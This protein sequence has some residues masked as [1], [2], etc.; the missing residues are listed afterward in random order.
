GDAEIRVGD[1][2]P[3]AK[4]RRYG[5]SRGD[6]VSLP[7]GESVEEGVE[8]AHLDRADDFKSFAGR[9]RELDGKSGRRAV[10]P[11]EVQRRKI[12]IDEKTDRPQAGQVRPLVFQ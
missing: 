11:G 6:H 3:L 2:K 7:F 12:V 1:G 9:A 8:A 5:N 10:R 4:A